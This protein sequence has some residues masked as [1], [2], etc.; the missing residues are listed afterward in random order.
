[1]AKREN[2]VP[3][4][5]D[6]I[7]QLEW[8]AQHRRRAPIRFEPKWNYKILYRFSP[9]TPVERAIRI[10]L[11]IGVILLIIYWVGSDA[12][13]EQAGARIFFGFVFGLIFMILFFAVRDGAKDEDDETNN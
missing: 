8:K 13:I 6:Y 5:E 12:L 9:V 1:M 10:S 3:P 2:D 4:A 7:A 11:L